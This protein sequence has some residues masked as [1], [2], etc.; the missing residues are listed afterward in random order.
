MG[1]GGD[2]GRDAMPPLSRGGVSEL[3]Q[4]L[5]A[6]FFIECYRNH[7]SRQPEKE[8]YEHAAY[9]WEAHVVSY[10]EKCQ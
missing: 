6:I 8:S 1:E 4:T 7:H 3:E 5:K 9:T 2:E 10:V